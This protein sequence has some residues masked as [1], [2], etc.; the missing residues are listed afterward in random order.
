MVQVRKTFPCLEDGSL[1][2]DAW[3]RMLTGFEDAEQRKAMRC[4]CEMSSEAERNDTYVSRYGKIKC[5]SAGL[6]MASILSELH[7]DEPALI[8]AVIY[9]AVRERHI[10]LEVV[11]KKLGD[12]VATLVEGVL[13]MAAIS[14]F[15][16]DSDDQVLGQNQKQTDNMRKMLV[17][18]VD[19]VRVGVLK[20]A[21]RT[22]AIR[23]V[24]NHPE[25]RQRKVAQEVIDVYAPL[26]HRL[27]IGQI[28][29][30]L[31][32]L[33]F[34]YLQPEDYARIAELLKEK[35]IDRDAYIEDTIQQVNDK[36]QAQGIASSISG[37]A[38]HIYSIWRKMTRKDVPFDQLY[39][40]RAIRVLV[41]RVSDCYAALGAIHT[42]WRNISSEFDDYIANPK[43]NGYRSLHTAVI[44]P[45][46]KVLEMQIR[47]EE[48]H[49]EAELGICAHWLY[50]GT[51][52]NA[53]TD[54]YEKKIGWLRE[55][56]EWHEEAGG[57]V[58][59]GDFQRAVSRNIENDRIY[60]LTPQGHVV[61]IQYGSTP[62][63]FAYHIHTEVGH[64]CRGAKVNGRMVPLNTVLKNGQQIEILTGKE[65]RPNR[66][67]LRPSL[68][69]VN[70]T[71]AKN[72]LRAYFHRQERDDKIVTG[73]H[74]VEKELKRLSLTSID[75][76]LI[77][78]EFGFNKVDDFFAALASSDIGTTQVVLK[79]ERLFNLAE[80]IQGS[81][82][83]NAA[84]ADTQE[85][86]DHVDSGKTKASGTEVSVAGV[87][88]L[89][90][91]QAGCCKPVPGDRVIG[92]V[93]TQRGITVHRRDCEEFAQMERAQPERV[94]PVNWDTVT[95]DRY[96]VDIQIE[97][98][99][100][101]G[102]LGDITG[103]LSRSHV[104]VSGINTHTDPNTQIA[105]MRISIQINDINQ[106]AQIM[107]RIATVA[108][109]INVERCR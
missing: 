41:E 104:N 93:S 49:K 64:K 58:H 19:D 84:E 81:L 29:W 31:E 88:N 44:G 9:R 63:D 70:S 55:V 42:A 22:Q 62:V 68:G 56:L 40:L 52:T 53:K 36:L 26:A 23:S 75:Y 76:K 71:R 28:K 14:A 37:R 108:N 66:D 24:K 21:E 73:K 72:K 8:A 17:S 69:Y 87:A 3:I 60:V 11:R 100:R 34:R 54:S 6:E 18:M 80:E 2:T 101:T 48:M 83:T 95:R 59:L 46:N 51:D 96:A 109:V 4:A 16:S 43:A 67:W 30:E 39:D 99:D 5:F 107:G 90:T 102:L 27:G 97:G 74:L 15:R 85:L 57:N 61:D 10:Q 13:R 45:E 103:L 77:A 106:L 92:Y 12:E 86:L 94:L 79:A 1:D 98:Y 89:M 32:D 35:R 33:S 105:N 7:L 65:P 82:F 38:K 91:T 20:L 78:K 47:T 25:E 50:K